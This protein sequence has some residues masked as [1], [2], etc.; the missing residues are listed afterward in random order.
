MQ[1]SVC[2]ACL[3]LCLCLPASGNVPIEASLPPLVPIAIPARTT[4]NRRRGLLLSLS[5]SP[6]PQL[7]PSVV[8]AIRSSFASPL[9]F[10]LCSV[11]HPLSSP[12]F[13]P[14]TNRNALETRLSL[15]QE[16]GFSTT[17]LI[18]S[19]PLNLLS[20]SSAQSYSIHAHRRQFQCRPLCHAGLLWL[21]RRTQMATAIN[22]IPNTS[23]QTL[24]SQSPSSPHHP[25][26]TRR[27]SRRPATKMPWTHL[28]PA[29][30]LWAPRRF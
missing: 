23:V 16:R 1:C 7:T 3:Y 22:I 26:P 15:L 21:S 24:R 8:R 11:H 4:S 12:L 30:P 6:H 25:S 18:Q 20:V 5:L 27:P 9:V 17:T 19:H 2:L 14:H 28:L 10:T 13:C 29:L